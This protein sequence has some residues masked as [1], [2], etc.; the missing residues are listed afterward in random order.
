MRH[1][2]ALIG[3][4]LAVAAGA[5]VAANA[6]PAAAAAN[7][8]QGDR[9]APYDVVWANIYLGPTWMTQTLNLMEEAAADLQDEGLVGDF[10]VSNADGDSS[11]QVQQI[12]SA[13]DAGA[14]L[15]VVTAGSATALNRVVEQACEKGVAVV[16]FDSLVTTDAVTAKINTDQEK[17]GELSATWLV[18]Q[19]G[20]KGKILALN[21]PAGVSVSEARFE[22][23]KP[24]LEAAE[25]IEIVG[26]TNTQYNV[27]PAQEAVTNLL[28][29]NPELDG[30]WSQG[31]ALSAGAILAMQRVGRDMVPITGENYRQ[32]LELWQDNGLDAWAT[33][34]PNWMG[35]MS[36][37]IGVAGLEGE[38][39]PAY[40]D[41]PLPEITNDNL[42]EYVE[43]GKEFPDDGYVYPPFS[44][45]YAMELLAR[46]QSQ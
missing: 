6:G 17:W 22:G 46:A 28:F 29:A 9:S 3:A 5:L 36:I 31:G 23:A 40:I 38:D 12:Q 18:D 43:R 10:T 8:I 37:Y 1:D 21:G 27:A 44:R 16:N 7:C 20:G 45:E 26:T 13:I 24:V 4:T 11:R 32:F 41:V 30:I 35:A 25:G 2:R 42:A 19:L 14:D 15:I 33:G 34:Q 39:V